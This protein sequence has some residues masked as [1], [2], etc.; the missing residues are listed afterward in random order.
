M[1]Y[2]YVLYA[3]LS[4]SVLFLVLFPFFLLL[5]WMGK[6]GRKVIWQLIRLWSYIW[7]FLIG[8]PVKRVYREKPQKG[9][10]YIVVANHIS[11]LDTAM[12]FRAI[13]FYVRPLAKSELARIPLF[14]YLYRQMA[15]LVARSD[16]KSRLKSMQHLRRTLQREG[17]IFIFP[18]GAFNETGQ[19]LKSFYDGAFRLAINTGTPILPVLF[20]DTTRRWHYKS[21]WS[22]SPGVS[23]AVFLP[24]VSVTGLD[25]ADIP[26]IKEQV[27]R[28][29]EA[30]LIQ[31]G[32]KPEGHV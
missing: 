3:V 14:G 26:K 18:E 5:G 19:P 1:R 7:F 30:E 12:I 29:M 21:F 31:L 15:V 23:R 10:P 25:K 13:P 11:Y 27:Y 9:R 22:W 17:S 2:L 6:W 28:M 8:M 24:E 16:P 32:A 4:F 20:P